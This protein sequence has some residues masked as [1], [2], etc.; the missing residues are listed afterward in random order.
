MKVSFESQLLMEAEKT[1]IGWVADEVIRA[2]RKLEPD[3][4][5]QLNYFKLR[6]RSAGRPAAMEE[7]IRLGFRDVCAFF[8][9][10][11]YKM[12][13]NV[14]RIPYSF[15]FGKDSD[16]T[17]FFNYYIPPGVKG[18]KVT[19]FHDMTYKVYPETVRTR[20][21][22]M[23]NANMLNA[24]KRADKIIAVSEFTKQEI[25]KYLPVEA[26]RIVVMPNGVKLD[27]FRP[28]YTEEEVAAA[29]ERNHLPEKYLLY[30]GTL[31]PRKNIERLIDAYG[32]LRKE[33][34]DVPKLVL[35]GRKGWLYDTIFE[36]VKTLGLEQDVIFTG[37]VSNADAP[38]LMK[39]AVA[40]VFP[41]I[42][43]GFGMPP[44]EAM[45]CGTP[46][47]TSNVS[48]LPEVV[49]DCGVLVDPYSVDE[50][51]EGLKRLVNDDKLRADLSE[52][53]IRRAQTFTWERSA[54]IVCKVFRELQEETDK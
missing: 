19:I 8:S 44:L 54:E 36:K 29:R 15:F 33:Q 51:K 40:F 45:A 6:N 11:G 49:G 42:Y 27:K 53:G 22:M 43:E 30:L 16:V 28:D 13:W 3:W 26:D 41:S 4:E 7:Y 21:R 10:S 35:A 24:C 34:E 20:T 18:K 39:G 12:M 52:R 5:L 25:M 31:E 17:F 37:Y 9:Y 47:L 48:S 1:G 50:I 46:V 23:L 38:L 2:I 32:L 14:V